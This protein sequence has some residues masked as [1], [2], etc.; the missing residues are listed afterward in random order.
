M[1][2]CAAAESLPVPSEASADL[3]AATIARRW[4]TNISESLIGDHIQNRELSAGEIP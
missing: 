2:R 3:S 4:T 1:A